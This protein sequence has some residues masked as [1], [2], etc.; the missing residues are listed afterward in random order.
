MWLLR[1]FSA[2]YRI[3]FIGAFTAQTEDGHLTYMTRFADEDTPA[4]SLGG[5]RRRREWAA[6]K[7]AARQSGPLLKNQLISVLLPATTGLLLS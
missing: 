2:A 6:A 3:E 5:L 7:T 1:S 4:E